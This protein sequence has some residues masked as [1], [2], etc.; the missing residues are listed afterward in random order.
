MK[1]IKPIMFVVSGILLAFVFAFK[2]NTNDSAKEYASLYAYT[3]KSVLYLPDQTE[4]A[5]P[6]KL[7]THEQN[8]TKILNELNK[9][10]WELSSSN[11]STSYILLFLEREKK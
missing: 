6:Y 9:E 7:N 11:A 10:G 2:S 3:Y 8:I 4:K 5:Y 1:T